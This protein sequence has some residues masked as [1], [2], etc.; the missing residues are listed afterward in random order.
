MI[1]KIAMFFKNILD[2]YKSDLCFLKY[3]TEAIK[4]ANSNIILVTPLIIFVIFTTF[5]MV[6]SPLSA[7]SPLLSLLLLFAIIAMFFS[8]WLY[9]IKLAVSAENDKNDSLDLLKKFPSGVGK[10]FLDLFFVTLIFFLL[11]ALVIVVTYK[12]AYLLI[13][14]LG[15]SRPELFFALSSPESMNTLFTNLTTEQQNKLLY[16]NY[17]FLLTTTIYSFLIM[18]WTP[19]IMFKKESVI[20]SLIGSLLK[21]FK[22]FFKSLSLFMYLMFL[23]LIISILTI[24][25]KNPVVQYLCTVVYFYFLVYAAVL[26]FLFYKREFCENE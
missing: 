26:I 6:L 12:S 7:V 18:F 15:I 17:Y 5:Y 22:K 25:F 11:L 24:L 19:E 23:Y 4:V 10:H 2:W 3:F 14:D 16:W 13:G 9:T 1:E 21:L 8:G 20:N